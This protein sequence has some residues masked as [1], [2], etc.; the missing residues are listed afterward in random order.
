MVIVN[1]IYEFVVFI[2]KR[3][4]NIYWNTTKFIHSDSLLGIVWFSYKLNNVSLTGMFWLLLFLFVNLFFHCFVQSLVISCG[5]VMNKSNASV[6]SDLVLDPGRNVFIFSIF[7]HML[8]VGLSF[9]GF[10]VMFLLY[11]VSQRISK[12]RMHVLFYQMLFMHILD[13]TIFLSTFP[14]CI[15][16]HHFSYIITVE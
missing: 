15:L 6:H 3:L 13:H 4:L 1:D 14:H 11:L 7:D 8:A 12:S 2:D 16:H 5:T 9:V 10:K